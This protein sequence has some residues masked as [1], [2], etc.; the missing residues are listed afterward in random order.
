MK[1]TTENVETERW[2]ERRQPCVRGNEDDED[3]GTRGG[4]SSEQRRVPYGDGGER[5]LVDVGQ[6]VDDDGGGGEDPVRVEEGVEEVDGEE[7]Q[8]RQAL[9]QPLHAGVADLR[10][11]AGVERLAEADV[12]V[13]FVQ[14]GVGPSEETSG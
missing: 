10:D 6:L 3:G 5:L 2:S 1:K 8:V 7:P 12:D 11:L 13:V 14:P 9:Q 4:T